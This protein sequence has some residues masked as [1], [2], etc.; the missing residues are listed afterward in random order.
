MIHSLLIFLLL[1]AT[2]CAALEVGQPA[3]DLSAVQWIS[4]VSAERDQLVVILFTTSIPDVASNLNSCDERIGD[5]AVN[6]AVLSPEPVDTLRRFLRRVG[7][8]DGTLG[9]LDA[10]NWQAW[11]NGIDGLPHAV[12]IDRDGIVRWQGHPLDLPALSSST[13]LTAPPAQP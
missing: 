11:T 8:F 13:E 4:P 5:R 3:P 6:L 7:M 2:P 10:D 9:H 1:A 12:V